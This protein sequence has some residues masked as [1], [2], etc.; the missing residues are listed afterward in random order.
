MDDLYRENILEHYKQPRNWGE[1]ETPDLEFED[2]N[3]LCGDELK[4]QL[5]G[6][7]GRAHR[8]RPLLRPRLRDLAGVGVDGLRGGRSGCR[9]TT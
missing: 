2:N 8:R 1:L 4:V 9:S 3:P 7:R 6:R 5:E